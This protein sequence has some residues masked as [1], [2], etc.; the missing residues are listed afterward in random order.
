MKKI[1]AFLLSL[2]LSLSMT[3]CLGSEDIHTPE[4]TT[5]PFEQTEPTTPE[6]PATP[7]LPTT[8]EL[9]STPELPYGEMLFEN[10]YVTAWRLGESY[11]YM[12]QSRTGRLVLYEPSKSRPTSAMLSDNV[13][14]I[15]LTDESGVPTARFYD[16]ERDLLSPVYR[17][18]ITATDKLVAYLDGEASDRTLVVKSIFDEDG[19]E[20]RVKLSSK[21]ITEPILSATIGARTV[22][23]SYQCPGDSYSNVTLVF[24]DAPY[25]YFADYRSILQ[26][27]DELCAIASHYSDPTD[28]ATLLGITDPHQR[29]YVYALMRS[30][31]DLLDENAVQNQTIGYEV[32]DLDNN[33]SMELILLRKDHAVIAV[34]GVANGKPILLDHY[35]EKHSCA[36]DADGRL[37][38]RINGGAGTVRNLVYRLCEGG[39]APELITEFGTELTVTDG[40]SV[41]TYYNTVNG[42]VTPIT[43]SEYDALLAQL[44]H[45]STALTRD[46]AKLIFH[47]L[48]SHARVNLSL[49]DKTFRDVLES[50]IPIHDVYLHE[51]RDPY[52]STSLREM[53]E[54]QYAVI[55]V[56]GTAMLAVDVSFGTFLIY[57][58][59]GKLYYEAYSFNTLYYLTSDGRYSFSYGG[60]N[61]YGERKLYLENGKLQSKELWKILNDGEPNAEYY[62]DGKQVTRDELTGYLATLPADGDATFLPVRLSWQYP[63]SA[64]KAI[65]LANTYWSY[66]DGRSEGACGTT[67]VFHVM[68]DQGPKPDFP[69]YTIRLERHCYSHAEVTEESPSHTT[70]EIDLCKTLLVNVYTGECIELQ[71]LPPEDGK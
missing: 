55:D 22:S 63:I 59:E 52:L 36:I 34:F 56:D 25:D 19:Y 53:D 28:Y 32:N 14:V 71:P 6:L 12:I 8:P 49:L 60:A 18:E 21:A 3:S 50:K 1:T 42:A 37:H 15:R 57:P 41:S 48:R 54:L 26:L 20:K 44:P 40:N 33:G 7:E 5:V 43:K 27:T 64:R 31:F 68:F 30:L 67:I 24:D 35:G 58:H 65:T 23:L 11:D 46:E 2:S 38:V 17:Y 51:L 47:P 9:P 10:R 4:D 70:C 16:G 29:E 66:P 13:A 62:L 45:F 39:D 69:Y 61:H